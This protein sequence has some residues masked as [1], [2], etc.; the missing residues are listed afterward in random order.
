MPII[1]RI[2]PRGSQNNPDNFPTLHPIYL[3][4]SSKRLEILGLKSRAN[5]K[6]LISGHLTARAPRTESGGTI[7]RAFLLPARPSRDM[8]AGTLAYVPQPYEAYNF[9]QN[10]Y[11]PRLSSSVQHHQFGKHILYGCET[12]HRKATSN[13]YQI[14]STH[15]MSPPGGQNHGKPKHPLD[16]PFPRKT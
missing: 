14:R 1:P 11:A 12:K 2:L 10:I 6:L 13:T 5:F 4:V 9:P 16:S 3:T 7:V 8:I 15:N